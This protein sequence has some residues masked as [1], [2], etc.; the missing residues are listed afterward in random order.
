MIG[1]KSAGY[2]GISASRIRLVHRLLPEA[3]LILMVRDPVKRHWSHAKR[4]F[5]RRNRSSGAT[6]RSTRADA[7]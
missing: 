5:R 6:T 1:E 7:I 3:R 4:Y 2:C